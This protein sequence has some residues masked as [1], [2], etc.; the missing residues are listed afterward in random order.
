M[1]HYYPKSQTL[2][3]GAVLIWVLCVLAIRQN[4]GLGLESRGLDLACLLGL[5]VVGYLNTGTR[6]DVDSVSKEVR[7]VWRLVGLPV[8]WSR[9][10]IVAEGIELRP[11]WM[12]WLRVQGGSVKGIQKA[13]VYDMVLVG[14]EDNPQEPPRDVVIELKMDQMLFTL[15]ERRARAVGEELNLPVAVRWDRMF[16]D[17]QCQVREPGEWRRRFAYPQEMKDWRKWVSW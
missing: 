16:G 8:R 4:M 15:S 17:L 1:K 3:F 5:G 11:E 7:R 13:L 6:V 9:Q 2:Q 14:H 10:D 12:R